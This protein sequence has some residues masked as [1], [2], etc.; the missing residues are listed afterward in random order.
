MIRKVAGLVALFLLGAVL[1]FGASAVKYRLSVANEP[2]TVI[3]EGDFG[4]AVTV[5]AS[6]D[7][8]F[9]EDA[10]PRLEAERDGSGRI[11]AEGG[12]VLARVTS[13]H[14]DA[15]GATNETGQYYVIGSTS[16]IPDGY[17][18]YILGR[19][20]GSRIVGVEPESTRAATIRV[21]DVLPT[22]LIGDHSGVELPAPLPNVEL[23]DVGIPQVRS[24]GGQVSELVQADLISGNGRQVRSGDVA[25][26]NYMLVSSDGS[27]SERTW[28]NPAP[29]VLPVDD[30]FPGLH[31]ALVDERV[32][33]R[34]A[35]AVPAALAQGDDVVLVVDIL[36]SMPKD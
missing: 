17:T 29:V 31:G 18:A 4:T 13:F 19:A 34:I 28:L 36:A 8:H 25:V 35:V 16:D 23:D 7:V 2:V 5:R 10:E 24:A 27:V 11:V 15:S 30:V 9:P 32:G 6:G 26:V 22:V 12:Q 14:L 33:S 21:V 1:G 3:V 20:E